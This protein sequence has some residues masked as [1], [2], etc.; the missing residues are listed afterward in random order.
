MKN[1]PALQVSWSAASRTI[2][3]EARRERTAARSLWQRR[4]PAHR[5]P[6][7]PGQFG[8]ADRRPEDRVGQL[9]AN[10]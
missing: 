8:V 10:P 2:P 3:L 7:G 4:L 1:E 9:E 6:E 5:N